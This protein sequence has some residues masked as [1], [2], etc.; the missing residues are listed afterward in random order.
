MISFEN[1]RGRESKRERQRETKASLCFLFIIEEKR[2]DTLELL[3][4]KVS[5][6]FE[7]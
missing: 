2:R 1:E 5:K 4:F 3:F 6:P 7:I